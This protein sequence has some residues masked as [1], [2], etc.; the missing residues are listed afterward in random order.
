[1]RYET[2]SIPHEGTI[3]GVHSIAEKSYLLIEHGSIHILTCIVTN[4]T[5]HIK[6]PFHVQTF[7]CDENGVY[8][9][10]LR[11]N[12]AQRT[13]SAPMILALSHDGKLLWSHKGDISKKEVW[14]LYSSFPG[15]ITALYVEKTR[16]HHAFHFAQFDP[17]GAVVWKTPCPSVV[18][19]EN[20]CNPKKIPPRFF[21]NT[22][23]VFCVGAFSFPGAHSA[24]SIIGLHSQTGE[25]KLQYSSPKKG[26]IYT[27]HAR[28]NQ[29]HLAIAW[30]PLGVRNP[31]T[32]ILLFDQS[33]TCVG[34][35]RSYLHCWMGM[36]WHNKSLLLSGKSRDQIPRPALESI[37][38]EKFFHEFKAHQLIGQT[39]QRHQRFFY[40]HQKS[41]TLRQLV[42]RDIFDTQILD[43]G[44]HLGTPFHATGIHSPFHAI[45]YN[46][47]ELSTLIKVWDS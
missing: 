18:L 42:A 8:L 43:E 33:L 28:S 5:W 29:G 37:G 41:A 25:I 26:G 15:S 9:G 40:L 24:I 27:T 1:M 32:G 46:N 38:K 11:Y 47:G 22:D 7:S 45:A 21:S 3:L 23:G 39:H 2:I 12:N 10:G 17:S 31:S 16:E 13:H 4:P 20:Y 6:L 34:E 14:A 36:T 19:Q 30:Q 35:Y 44:Q